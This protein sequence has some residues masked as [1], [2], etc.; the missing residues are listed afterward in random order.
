MLR[1]FLNTASLIGRLVLGVVFIYASLY[2][3]AEPAEFA[4]SIATYDIMSLWSINLMAITLPWIELLCG[5]LIIIGLYTRENTLAIGGMLVVF[6]IAI[7][8]ALSRGTDF[9]CGCFASAEAGEQIAWATL[10]CDVLLLGVVTLVMTIEGRNQG[11]GLDALIRKPR[12]QQ[13]ATP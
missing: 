3:I 11:W 8:V 6:V 10:W 12:I 2:K 5:G 1:I 7:G 9:S 4:L 13:G